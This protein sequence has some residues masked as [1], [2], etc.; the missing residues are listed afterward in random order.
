MG[1][2]YTNITLAPPAAAAVAELAAV[3]RNAYVAE[4]RGA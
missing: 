4:R 3:G 1:S 2:F